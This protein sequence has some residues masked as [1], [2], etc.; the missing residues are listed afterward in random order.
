MCA[1]LASS[2]AQ[3]SSVALAQASVVSSLYIPEQIQTIPQQVIQDVNVLPSRVQRLVTSVLNSIN[4]VS[5]VSS[6]LVTHN[7]RSYVHYVFSDGHSCDILNVRY[8]SFVKIVD[9]V[10]SE[11]NVSNKYSFRFKGLYNI[12]ELYYDGEFVRYT[13]SDNR[14]F[15]ASMK[16]KDNKKAKPVNIHRLIAQVFIYNDDESRLVVNHRD[17]N[18]LNACLYNLEYLTYSENIQINNI[19]H[20]A[21]VDSEYIERRMN[22]KRLIRIQ[23]T[24]GYYDITRL[25]VYESLKD[26]SYKVLPVKLNYWNNTFYYQVKKDS[27]TTGYKYYD[28]SEL[29]MLY[30][31]KRYSEIIIDCEDE[32]EYLRLNTDTHH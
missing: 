26:G 31:H 6:E 9:Y 8:D 11:C 28:I 13:V 21:Y 30:S 1:A 23:G 19:T 12:P 16:N 2:V 29:F 7:N 32:I 5:V 27:K 24:R 14:Y 3:A 25:V 10:D 15:I 4:S 17:Q 18:T 20:F 22:L